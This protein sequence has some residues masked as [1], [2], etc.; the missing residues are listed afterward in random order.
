MTPKYIHIRKIYVTI[1]FCISFSWSL[2]TW[3]AQ[4]QYFLSGPKLKTLFK[5][6]S[7]EEIATFLTE[8]PG[9]EFDSIK[10]DKRVWNHLIKKELPKRLIASKTLRENLAS[11]IPILNPTMRIGLYKALHKAAQLDSNINFNDIVNKYPARNESEKNWL[12]DNNPTTLEAN[13]KSIIRSI[14]T[15]PSDEFRTSNLSTLVKY[16][17]RIKRSNNTKK[18]LKFKEELTLLDSNLIS[19][20]SMYLKLIAIIHT[21][22][23]SFEQIINQKIEAGQLLPED[24]Y[25]GEKGV[26]LN[27]LKKILLYTN[28][29][30]WQ[31]EN[32]KRAA[33]AN[34]ISIEKEA[35][36]KLARSTNMAEKNI[37]LQ[38]FPMVCSL[39]EF[40]QLNSELKISIFSQD[41]NQRLNG[42]KTYMVCNTDLTILYEIATKEQNKEIIQLLINNGFSR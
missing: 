13:L 31:N 4:N 18:I 41:E 32:E 35:Y 27:I 37:F 15:A 3:K 7:D 36:F 26:R 38:S 20:N 30:E 2:E 24:L 34:L 22:D 12:Y 8:G 5:D 6:V 10:I 1:L 19:N 9:T 14:N 21:N 42:I 39:Q 11:K 16:A 33:V 40:N 17:R 23:N 29:N 25:I 28:Q